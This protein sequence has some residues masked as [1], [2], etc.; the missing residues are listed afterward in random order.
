MPYTNVRGIGVYYEEHGSGPHHLLIAHGLL[1]SASSTSCA[2]D[3][4]ALGMHVISY[5]TRGHGKTGYTTRTEDYCRNALAEDMRGLLDA[6][7]LP[8]VSIF[9]SSMG[10]GTAL[11]FAI[12][13]PDRVT[14]LVLRSPPGFGDDA[15]PARRA[16]GKL[17]FLYRYLGASATARIVAMTRG[18][19]ANEMLAML[20]AQRAVAIDTAIR[21][22]LVEGP[23]FPVEDLTRISAPT[24]ILAH[25]HDRLHP[26]S[27]G[28]LLRDRLRGAELDVAADGDFWK[29]HPQKLARRIVDFAMQHRQSPR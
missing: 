26:L 13:C 1:G 24:L 17:A 27:S 25:R 23:P 11:L 2:A 8:R 7:G 9:G 16:M 18:G 4:A 28:E 29:Q 15:I 20:R 6:L 3:I 22:L 5:D 19:R 14:S 10:A 21:G 12:A